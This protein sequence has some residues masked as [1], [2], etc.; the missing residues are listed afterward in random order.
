M[1]EFSRVLMVHNYYRKRGGEDLSF[2]AEAGLLERQG[3]DVRRLTMHSREASNMSAP[4]LAAS[5]AWNRRAV[6]NLKSAVREFEP[7]V[8]HIQNTF[9]LIS[10]A[11]CRA[12]HK[13]GLPVVMALRNYRLFCAAGTFF[14]RGR[15]CRDCLDRL[16]PWPAV[17][18][19]CYREERLK[20]MALALACRLHD[21]IGTWRDCVDIFIAASPEAG[22]V[23]VRAGLPADKIEIKPNFLQDGPGVSGKR[24]EFAL[25]AG[26]LS[27]EKGVLDL[28]A[29]W[30][31]QGMALPLRIVGN[32]P[33]ETDIRDGIRYAENVEL[34][35]WQS[36]ARILELMGLSLIHI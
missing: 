4:R 36:H 23:F 25:Y 2:E 7:Q 9:P 12:A 11:I 26:R 17:V 13:T 21:A 22:E 30:K 6:M 19:G 3:H 15:V 35:G 20:S 27:R 29:A 5:L 24:R 18:H 31:R 1:A 10:P 16:L 32:G 28:V 14:R 34:Q 8:I 33:L